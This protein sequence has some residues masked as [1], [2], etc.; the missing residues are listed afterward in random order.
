[1]PDIDTS[2]CTTNTTQQ[3]ARGVYL[4]RLVLLL[5]TT[6]LKVREEC[7]LGA[8]LPTQMMPP[9]ARP[10]CDPPLLD[11]PVRAAAVPPPPV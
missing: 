1:M 2:Q 3:I 7:R 5:C 10:C 11:F 4:F 6:F 8:V 9:C